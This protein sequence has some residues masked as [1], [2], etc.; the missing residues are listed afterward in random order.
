ML[1]VQRWDPN[2]DGVLTAGRL[3]QRFEAQGL[4]VSEVHL[5]AGAQESRQSVEH[6]VLQV[7][8]NGLLKTTMGGDSA[9]L[10]AG[11]ALFVPRGTVVEL[12]AVGT[13]PVVAY[14][15]AVLPQGPHVSGGPSPG[16]P[17]QVWRWPGVS[18]GSGLLLR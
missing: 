7:V 2:R 12:E 1:Q 8:L 13:T 16:T 18:L 4:W 14:F 3:R 5:G 6:D 11:D 15:A 17:E 9:I 10:A